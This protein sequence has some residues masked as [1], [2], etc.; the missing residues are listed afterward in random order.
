MCA[1]FNG[2][3]GPAVW[4]RRAYGASFDIDVNLTDGQPHEVAVDRD[5]MWLPV[6][7]IDV[8]VERCAVCAAPPHGR[9]RSPVEGR[10][11]LSMCCSTS[12]TPPACSPARMSDSSSRPQQ[13]PTPARHTYQSSC[14]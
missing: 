8:D 14:P 4:R 2:R 10:T 13:C 6:S 5:F 3:A 12:T 7:E 9:S 11:H 1:P